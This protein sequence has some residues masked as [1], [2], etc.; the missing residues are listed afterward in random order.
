M[1]H[2]N[3]QTMKAEHEL[4]T[5]AS[6]G[7]PGEQESGWLGRFSFSWMNSVFQLG[8]KGRA[9]SANTLC[10]LPADCASASVWSTFTK[11]WAADLEVPLSSTSSTSTTTTS[12]SNLPS[13]LLSPG[14]NATIPLET[15]S[16]FQI[17]SKIFMGPLIWSGLMVLVY[18]GCQIAGPILLK[19]LL[20]ELVQMTYFGTSR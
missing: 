10:R 16:L 5:N 19:Q 7:V 1:T 14:N 12:E 18:S 20:T 4:P 3:T 17:T 15:Q 6:N 11:H 8:S 13:A 2:N 9:L